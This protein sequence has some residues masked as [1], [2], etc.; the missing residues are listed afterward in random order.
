V[1]SFSLI[2]IIN[3][4]CA[5]GESPTWHAFRQSW[6]WTDILNK[7]LYELPFGEVTPRKIGILPQMVT[8]ISALN[9]DKV[10]ITA[11]NF[12]AELSLNSGKIENRVLIPHDSSMR[13]NDGVLGPDGALWF[14]TMKKEPDA[15]S[16]QIL[17][18]EM[19]TEISL[20]A[21]KI[22]IPNT[23][24]WL[25]ENEILIS[26]SYDNTIYSVN[27]KGNSLNWAEREVWAKYSKP[28]TPDGGVLDENQNLI[29]ALWGGSR[30]EVRNSATVLAKIECPMPNITACTIGG[31]RSDYL[32]V[33]TARQGLSKQQLKLAPESGNCLIFKMS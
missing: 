27:K 29:I 13:C 5:L 25:S 20:V 14:G 6:I 24:V 10:L 31:P 22:G 11:E 3:C 32:F 7:Y 28:V 19:G 33:T 9:D 12:V 4:N 21:N 15:T 30:L 8:N 18:Y 16:G 2:Q 23:F 17:R 26:D 1:K